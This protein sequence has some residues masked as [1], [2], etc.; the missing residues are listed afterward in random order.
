MQADQTG[1]K[2]RAEFTK[3]KHATEPLEV[4]WRGFHLHRI[5][6]IEGTDH[7]KIDLVVSVPPIEG[8]PAGFDKP[9]PNG[10]LKIPSKTFGIERGGDGAFKGPQQG[11]IMHNQFRAALPAP[12]Q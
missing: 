5:A 7:H 6:L 10:V 1:F 2:I 4:S 3:F 9:C 12:K 11:I 8:V